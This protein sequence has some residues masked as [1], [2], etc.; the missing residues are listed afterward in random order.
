MMSAS[1]VLDETVYTSLGYGGSRNGLGTPRLMRKPA[2][3]VRGFIAVVDEASRE[4]SPSHGMSARQRTWLA[5]GIPAVRVTNSMCWA[6][7]A[8][9]SLGPYALAALSWMLRH[10]QIPWDERLVARV[11]V[12]RGHDGLTAGSRV[13][14][15]TD[16]PRAQSA[17]AL[18]H[19]D[20]RR[21]QE[22]G[23]YLWGQRLVLL[24]FVTPTISIPVGVAFYQPA[25]ELS[26]WYK[27]E[28]ALKQP[29]VT[30]PPRPPKPPTNPAPPP[31]QQLA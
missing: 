8:R 19:L 27:T 29:G 6:R 12:I 24:W 7:F 31:T 15:D 3:L 16:H 1:V 18:A 11:R 21:D 5:C 25:P 4:Q 2:P 30:Q 20:T 26:A 17:K 9:A 10:R 13:L 28:K 22:R 14:D 23:G